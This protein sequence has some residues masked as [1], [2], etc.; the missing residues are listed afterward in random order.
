LGRYFDRGYSRG[1]AEAE[2]LRSGERTAVFGENI[3]DFAKTIERSPITMPIIGQLV[4]CGTS[5]GANYLE[6]DDAVSKNEFLKNIGTCK[7]EAR[8]TKHFLRMAVRASP[9]LKSRARPLWLD[10]AKIW[11]SKT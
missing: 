6:A 4:R 10:F 7:K 9:E 3:I 11:R 2:N 8:E 5:V 1:G